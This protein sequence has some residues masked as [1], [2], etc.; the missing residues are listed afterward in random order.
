MASAARGS[1]G[2]S[3][4]SGGPWK[5]GALARRTGLSVRTL[6]WYD[7]LGLLRP[8]RRTPSGHRLYGEAEVLRL[9]QIRSLR[10]LGLTLVEVRD[11]LRKPGFAPAKVVRLHL[12]EVKE[13]IRR[14]QHLERRL[15]R[16]ARRLES[17]GAVSVDDLMNVIEEITMSEQW[18]TPGQLA[19]VRERGRKLGDAAIR[20]VEAEW[21]V[22]IAKVRAEM[23]TGT[24]PADPR[25]QQL[26]RR[27]RELVEQFTGGNP[28]I[29]RA[30]A[31]HYRDDPEARARA[32]LD[33]AIFGY[34]RRAW[35]AGD[36]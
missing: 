16:L 36:A 4:R 17:A 23:E 19:E 30:V 26:A 5:I 9:Q 15:E 2:P 12:A 29:E 22:L 7:Q 13:Q 35:A 10:H 18:L 3:G 24:D 25:V 32:G 21:P 34:V 28:G 6:H 20:A 27:W 8:A 14:Q 1:D 11:A 31:Q 33:A